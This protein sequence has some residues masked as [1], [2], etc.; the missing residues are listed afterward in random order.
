[1]NNKPLSRIFTKTSKKLAETDSKKDP[2]S[3]SIPSL[4]RKVKSAIKASAKSHRQSLKNGK[5]KQNVLNVPLLG[6]NKTENL[7]GGL[8]IDLLIKLKEGFWAYF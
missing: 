4:G 1:M 5:L 2:F 7:K 6:I 8:V 3:T